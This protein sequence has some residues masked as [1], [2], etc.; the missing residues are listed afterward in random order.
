M[1]EEFSGGRTASPHVVDY[2]TGSIARNIW[3][4]AVPMTL[5][6]ISVV[7]FQLGDLFWVGQI[8]PQALAVV[9]LGSTMRW[10][11]TSLAVGL[12]TGGLAIVARYIGAHDPRDADRATAQTILLATFVAVVLVTFGFL[13]LPFILPIL[14]A[15]PDIYLDTLHYL[16]ITLAGLLFIV[17]MPVINT[18]F[19]GAGNARWAMVIGGGANIF[20]VLIEP[21][22]I[23]GW[24]PFPRLGVSGAAL[25]VVLTQALALALQLTLLL[26]GM[27]RIRLRLSFLMPDV[28]L[29]WRV[30]KIA[31]P[32]TVEMFLRA[33]SR[34]TLLGIVAFYGTFAIAGYGVANRLLLIAIIPGFGLGNAAA[35]LVGQNL[36]ARQPDRAERSV[37]LIALLN[38]LLVGAIAIFYLLFP[39]WFIHLFNGDARVLHHGSHCLRIVAISY[40]VLAV[41]IVAS[42]GLDGAGNTLPTMI[43]N[44]FTL[45]GIQI[46]LTYLLGRWGI[47]GADGVWLGLSVANILNGLVLA[48]W[49]RRGGWRRKEV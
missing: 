44:G 20:N 18:L 11:L 24:G 15:G 26:G 49:F 2:T 39:A 42:R 45:W 14:G 10:A 25:S 4:L 47:F 3:L 40:V 12:G 16:Y 27:L 48:Y 30:I 6:Q 31:I 37:W 41:G 34:V 38:L 9:S 5:E 35:T 13:T 17:L 8:A 32:S 33:T 36:G 7:I 1:A 43:I 29:I 46:P 19:R 21:F 28:Q 22:L 23:F